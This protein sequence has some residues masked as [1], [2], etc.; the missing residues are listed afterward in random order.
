MSSEKGAAFPTDGSDRVIEEESEGLKSTHDTLDSLARELR[1]L[2][3]KLKKA[4][5]EVTSLQQRLQSLETANTVLKDDKKL[6]VKI[7][8]Q[9]EIQKRS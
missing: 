9:Q 8:S 3:A 2:K 7:W 1:D 5:E 4:E 6:L